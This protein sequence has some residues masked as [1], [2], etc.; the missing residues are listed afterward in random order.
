VDY[1]EGTGRGLLVA[2]SGGDGTQYLSDQEGLPFLQAARAAG[3]SV[4][5]VKW[6]RSWWQGAEGAGIVAYACRPANVLWNLYNTKFNG[7]EFVLFGHSGGASQAAYAVEYY[8]LDV[9]VDRVLLSGG[10]PHATLTKSCTCAPASYCYNDALRAAIDKAYGWGDCAARSAA[11]TARW[12]ADSC[13]L[14]S[15][16][17]RH[18]GTTFDFFSGDQDDNAVR[19][20]SLDYLNALGAATTAT[21]WTLV[22]GTGHRVYATAQGRAAL[23]GALQ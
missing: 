13:A 10:P 3:W 4:A 14:S 18:P 16:N 2:L 11:G 20:A 6:S 19:Q 22:P 9:I 17:Y 12:D 8:G 23:L 5:Q 1:H 15:P 7:G 21:N